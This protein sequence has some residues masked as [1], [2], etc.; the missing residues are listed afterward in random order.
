MPPANYP[1][2]FACFG[3]VVELYGIIYLEVTRLT[4]RG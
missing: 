4:K 3:M 2:V 1:E